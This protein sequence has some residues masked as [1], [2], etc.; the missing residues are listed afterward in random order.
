M[1]YKKTALHYLYCVTMDATQYNYTVRHFAQIRWAGQEGKA[2]HKTQFLAVKTKET[3]E[4][5][6]VFH[7]TTITIVST[8]TLLFQCSELSNNMSHQNKNMKI[9]PQMK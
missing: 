3:L 6:L 5:P 9:G 1:I 2:G 4:P 7:K 8:T